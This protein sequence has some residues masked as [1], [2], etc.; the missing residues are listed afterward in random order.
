MSTFVQIE[1]IALANGVQRFLFDKRH[2]STRTS[3]IR[4][5]AAREV[6][7]VSFQSA[8]GD[9]VSLGDRD[10]RLP[11]IGNDPN[12]LKKAVSHRPIPLDLFRKASQNHPD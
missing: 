8:T 9:G 1:S 11:C 2:L 7:A 5:G 12:T 3:Q 6:I 4:E 10:E